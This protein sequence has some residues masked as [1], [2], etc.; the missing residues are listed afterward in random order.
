[1]LESNQKQIAAVRD[2]FDMYKHYL[3]IS[4]TFHRPKS[5][6]FTKKSNVS[7]KSMDLD[8]CLKLVTDFLCNTK[9]H[10]DTERC[11]FLTKNLDIDDQYICHIEAKKLPSIS[12]EEL[13]TVQIVL[14]DHSQL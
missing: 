13:L 8:N 4:Y 5:K 2:A 9:Y 14:K 7:R 12:D 6:F 11:G 10:E 3:F 1:M